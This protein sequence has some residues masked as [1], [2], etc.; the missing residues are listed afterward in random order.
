LAD[1]APTT[2]SENLVGLIQHDPAILRLADLLSQRRRVVATG[3]LGSIVALTAGAVLRATNRPVVLVLA[4]VDDADEALDELSGAGVPALRLPA[5]ETLPGESNVSMELF[6]ERLSTVRAVSELKDPAVI[7]APIQA[8]MQ[9]AVD[10]SRLGSLIRT[11]RRD[12]TVKLQELIAWLG[13]AGYTRVE[14]VEEPGDFALRGGILD[15]FPPTGPDAGGAATPVR[16]D[17]FGDQVERI[18]EIDLDTMATDR[19]V[20]RVDLVVAD[21]ARVLKEE[22]GVPFLELVPP[23]A[24]ALLAETME[25][26]EQGRGYF[27]RVAD[28]SGVLGPPAVLK[29][30]E[31]RFH[32][33]A[34]LNQFSVGGRAPRAARFAPAHLQ[35]G[36]ERG[37]WRAGGVGR[38]RARHLPEQRRASAAGRA[39]PRVRRRTRLARR[40]HAR[41]PPPR[42]H[43]G[44][45]F[46]HGSP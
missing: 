42:L 13:S 19:A 4:H 45:G 27:E 8:L 39:A 43:V 28:R 36:C 14:A 37:D 23:S 18:A 41:L 29:T 30:L 3:A 38:P 1:P 32:A 25:V 9:P 21:A 33:L 7:I 17:F 35:H 12:E 11:V 34:E 15:V 46:Q 26:V 44:P 31:T 40:K 2:P 6:A 24:V 22:R 16:L 20:E 10:P 5:L